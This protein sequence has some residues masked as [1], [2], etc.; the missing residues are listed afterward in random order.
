MRLGAAHHP[1]APPVPDHRFDGFDP[2]TVE[3]VERPRGK[4]VVELAPVGC[5]VRLQIV[6]H[7]LR[8]PNR[9][10]VRLHHQRRYRANY[11]GLCHAVF[12]MAGEVVHHLATASG[13]ANVNYILQIEMPG[14][15]REI[16]GVMVHAVPVAGL[17]GTTMAAAI[18]G[19]DP[20]AL[21]KEEQQLSIPIVCRERPAV[22]EHDGLSL[23]PILVENF[24]AV[25]GSRY[26]H[27]L[28]LT[29]TDGRLCTT[30]LDGNFGVS[31]L[32]IR[33]RLTQANVRY[34][35]LTDIGATV[36]KVR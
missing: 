16:V 36:E 17:S 9:I 2:W 33:F 3:A 25:L 5:D 10:G 28:T 32:S 6:E 13:V 21:A 20:I 26:W 15:R 11:G 23:T 18:M 7:C 35:S 14:H 27:A 8:Q 34:G 29:L 12:A 30:F 1:L 22:A 19:D 4:I 24:D 31:C